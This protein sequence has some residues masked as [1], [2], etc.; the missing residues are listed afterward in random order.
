MARAMVGAVVLALLG[1][2]SA[3]QS[4]ATLAPT[5]APRPVLSAADIELPLEGYR[6]G[7]ASVR[8]L[9]EA[10]RKLKADCARRYDVQV[11][12]PAVPDTTTSISR[13]V[14]RYGILS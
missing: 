11:S 7:V 1:A 12:D 10:T 3:E 4:E 6:P 8:L 13:V 5:V 2:C 9:F 14:R